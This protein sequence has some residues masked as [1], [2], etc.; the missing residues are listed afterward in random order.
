VFAGR[1][2]NE[3]HESPRL[4]WTI[5]TLDCGLVI[6]ASLATAIGLL[7]YRPWAL[8]AASAAVPFATCMVASVAGMAAAMERSHDPSAQPIM[9]AATVPVSVLFAG[10][11]C[12]LIRRL[13]HEDGCNPGD[14][15]NLARRSIA[16]R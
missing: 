3:Y 10:L 9:L 5:K 16:H 15:S 8:R 7:R 11:S 13:L 1:A 4:F 6:P 14:V 12:A 2:S